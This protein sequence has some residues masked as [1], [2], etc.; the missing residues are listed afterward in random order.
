[1]TGRGKRT[2][3]AIQGQLLRTLAREQ[4]SIHDL[5]SRAGVNWSTT[6]RQLIIL[7][8]KDLVREVFSH[9]RLRLFEITPKGKE[10]TPR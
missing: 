1:M 4:L 7:K 3:K 8:G 10:A 5:A 9:P 2:H 6:Q